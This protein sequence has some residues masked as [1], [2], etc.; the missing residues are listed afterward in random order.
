MMTDKNREYLEA[1][2]QTA[3]SAQL[4]MMLLDGAL[5]FAREAEKGV[6]R[7]EELAYHAPLT[8]TMDIVEELLA[9]VRHSEDD[10]NEK[11]A[12]LYTFI[13]MRLMSVYVNGDKQMMAE[14]LRVLEFQRETWRQAVDKLATDTK[15]DA[16][17][18]APAAPV[19]KKIPAPKPHLGGSSVTADIPVGGLSF[20]A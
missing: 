18:E 10:L 9:G 1:R 7:G 14:A 3:N 13:Y 17:A 11:L 4:H 5:R 16:K 20:E 6:L 8:R 2:V 12:N 15:G 19:A